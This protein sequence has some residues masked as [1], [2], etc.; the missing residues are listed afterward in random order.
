MG[1]LLVSPWAMYRYDAS[2]AQE[3][4]AKHPQRFGLIR[5]F[6]PADPGVAEAM[7]EW[8]RQSGVV[9]VRGLM[10]AAPAPRIADRDGID[11]VFAAGA[12]CDLPVNVLCWGNIAQFAA[13]AARHPNTQLVVD[14]VGL[15]QPF[16]PP[17]PN[18][19]LCRPRSRAGARPLRQRGHQ[20]L[21]GPARCRAS[22]FPTRTSGTPLARIF[23]A[24]GLARCLWGHGLDAGGQCADA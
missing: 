4:Q 8:A 13:A 5:P 11:R 14:H 15:K 24:F 22:R 10:M 1:A 6:D 2:Y 7:A 3:V 17:P 18:K 20:D 9:G 12:A 23:D 21:R 16:A 19:P